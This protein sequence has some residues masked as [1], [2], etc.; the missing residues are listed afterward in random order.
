M[1]FTMGTVVSFR[2]PPEATAACTADVQ[3]IFRAHDDRF[4][5]YKPDSELRQ[6]TDGRLLLSRSSRE[7]REMYA[8]AV[9]WR[10]TTGGLF[11]PHDPGGHLD[12]NGVVKAHAIDQAGQ[13]LRQQGVH[14]WSLNCG[15]DILC[16]GVQA[17]GT[18]WAI[19]IVNPTDRTTIIT[20]ITMSPGRTAIA[21]SGA[22][23]RGHH[24]WS[25]SGKGGGS[26]PVVQASVIAMDI[27]TAD[28]LA[29]TVCAGDTDIQDLAHRFKVQIFTVHA[30]GQSSTNP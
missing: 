13:Y 21:T 23:E 25:P 26:Q 20:T 2:A 4:S 14:D 12:L 3:K 17:P 19:G 22:S 10:N 5:L 28:V 9:E 30:D 15:G 18:P 8:L 16:S 29:T 27:L 7:V 24:I 1:F 6:V 11:D